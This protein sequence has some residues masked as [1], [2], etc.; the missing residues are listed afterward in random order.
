MASIQK[1]RKEYPQRMSIKNPPQDHA[2][3][4]H[5]VGSLPCVF[6]QWPA[7]GQEWSSSFALQTLKDLYKA[8][9]SLIYVCPM[10]TLCICRLVS[11][12]CFRKVLLIFVEYIINEHVILIYNNEGTCRVI[13]DYP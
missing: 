11:M 13:A 5:K 10:Y 4:K 2:H 1:S 7:C 9:L 3:R 6:V 12:C 8:Y